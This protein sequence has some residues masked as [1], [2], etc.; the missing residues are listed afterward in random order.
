MI[1]LLGACQSKT[2]VADMSPEAIHLGKILILPFK[3]MT[4]V[5]GENIDA[6]CPVCGRIFFTG[7]VADGAADI[8]TEKLV[9]WLQNHTNHKIIVSS[10]NHD[11]QSSY[12]SA[13]GGEL[14]VR[15]M[16]A[17]VG[18]KNR[19]DTV[20]AGFLY[21]FRER[22]GKGYS[23][24]SPASVAFS[25][26]LIRVSDAYPI[27]SAHFDETQQS[28][29]ENLFQLGSFLSRGGRWITAEELAVSGLEELLN[30]FPKS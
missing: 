4:Q 20:L 25:I 6:R 5:Q 27:W 17:E 16:L 12:F 3:D 24:E 30:K 18:R 2:E 1:G 28:L 14:V 19:V 26:H 21:R 23:I 11:N 22:V 29:G 8:L 7:K 13:S 9:S 15:K 10:Y